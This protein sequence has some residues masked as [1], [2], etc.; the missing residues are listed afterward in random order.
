MAETSGSRK[1][2]MKKAEKVI[3]AIMKLEGSKLL[4]NEPVDAE[5]MGLDDYFD[6]I[7]QPMDLGTIAQDLASREHYASASEVRTT[8]LFLHLFI[9][10]RKLEKLAAARTGYR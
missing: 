10:L 7:K 2:E 6:V 4:F 8:Q 1:I 3:S 5:K 9:R